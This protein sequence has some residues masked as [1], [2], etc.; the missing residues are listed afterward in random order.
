MQRSW[1]KFDEIRGLVISSFAISQAAF[2]N[3]KHLVSGAIAYPESR[4]RIDRGAKMALACLLHNTLQ[5]ACRLNGV[6]VP[7]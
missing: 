3:K 5:Q 1:Q 6:V 4:Y 2:E 7:E